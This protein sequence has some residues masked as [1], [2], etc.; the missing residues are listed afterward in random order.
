M[1]MNHRKK[2]ENYL[3]LA[4]K[5]T[6]DQLDDLLKSK[7]LK[8]RGKIIENG[9]Y[10]E[11]I[12]S[13]EDV[14]EILKQLSLDIETTEDKFRNHL[15][16]LRRH[17]CKLVYNRNQSCLFFIVEDLEMWDEIA[18]TLLLQKYDLL[19]VNLVSKIKLNQL[20][21]V[22]MIEFI[23]ENNDDSTTILRGISPDTYKS[24]NDYFTS[25]KEVLGYNRKFSN[26]SL[27]VAEGN[28]IYIE[29][30]ESGVSLAKCLSHCIVGGN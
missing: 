19:N 16:H 27:T 7:F 11:T 30:H 25:I 4:Y 29:L 23:T 5:C 28:R 20:P 10:K 3:A 1:R 17:L 14:K 22:N 2:E 15:D 24:N 21:E 26:F 8:F 13:T 6:S 18:S 9:I 12:I